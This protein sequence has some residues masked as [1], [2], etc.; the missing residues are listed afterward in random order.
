[1]SQH[2]KTMNQKYFENNGLPKDEDFKLKKEKEKKNAGNKNIY[3]QLSP[4]FVTCFT[5]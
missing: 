1:M 3:H 4:H 5:F 2:S